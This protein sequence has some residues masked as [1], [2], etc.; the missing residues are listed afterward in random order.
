MRGRDTLLY[1]PG[2]G[3]GCGGVGLFILYPETQGGYFDLAADNG[4]GVYRAL[5]IAEGLFRGATEF[6]GG[7]RLYILLLAGQ[8]RK[9]GA[10]CAG[11]F[12]GADGGTGHS[13]LGGLA[14]CV[15]NYRRGG[16]HF[17]PGT[18]HTEADPVCGA[19]KVTFVP[20][21]QCYGILRR[22]CGLRMRDFALCHP[23]V[24][25]RPKGR[26]NFSRDLALLFFE[27]NEII[28]DDKPLFALCRQGFFLFILKK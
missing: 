17:G 5:C 24:D 11:D 13:G 26:E 10:G 22:R 18:A 9:A 19:R 20:C 8:E 16:Q 15:G 2:I 6:S 3:C 27:E 21:I 4:L 25:P 12:R 28:S 7:H 1:R 14:L 23:R